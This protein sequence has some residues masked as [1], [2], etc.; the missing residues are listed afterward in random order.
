ME[1]AWSQNG[2]IWVILKTGGKKF[3]VKI[4]DDLDE[5]LR[6]PAVIKPTVQVADPAHPVQ[7]D[8]EPAQLAQHDNGPVQQA[9][10]VPLT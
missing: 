3:K 8:N 2:T 10:T 6:L 9:N 4:T 7:Q 5:K 1:S